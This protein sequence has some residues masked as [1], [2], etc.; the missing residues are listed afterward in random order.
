MGVGCEDTNTSSLDLGMASDYKVVSPE[1]VPCVQLEVPR[2]HLA[3]NGH[4]NLSSVV[5]G[6]AA[7]GSFNHILYQVSRIYTQLQNYF[8]MRLSAMS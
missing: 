3:D 7:Y 4:S 8:C 6:K 5:Y 2:E 1:R